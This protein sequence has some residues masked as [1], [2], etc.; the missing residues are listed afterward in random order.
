MSENVRSPPPTTQYTPEASDEEETAPSLPRRPMP[1]QTSTTAA[2]STVARNV[3]YDDRS[4]YH[5]YNIHEMVSHLGRKRKLP[6]VLGVDLSRG[7]ITI[8]P[9][10]TK[11]GPQREWTAEKLTNYSIEGKHVFMELVRPS[12]SIDFH[13]GNKDT[14]QEIVSILGELAGAARAEGLREVIAAGTGSGHKR[15]QMLYE[16]MAQG[17]D[18]VTVAVGDEVIVLDD[19]KSEEW[20]MVRRLK[21]GNE[22]VVPSSYVE[23]LGGAAS[24]ATLPAAASTSSRSY[25]EQNRM[26][27]ERLAREAARTPREAA[28]AEVCRNRHLLWI[29]FTDKE[30]RSTRQ[31]RAD[32][33]ANASKSSE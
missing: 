18:E 26:E 19:T 5:M 3:G 30:Q 6:M 25:A 20:W 8:S 16:F 14:A 23:I 10:K 4:D 11:D 28:P 2:S 1:T 15:G 22:G 7:V 33:K 24:S 31:S 21:N 32:S 17:D 29:H 9:E 27:E 13:A 12:K